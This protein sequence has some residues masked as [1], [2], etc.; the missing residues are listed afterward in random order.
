MK[1]T[2]LG[3]IT[4][5]SSHYLGCVIDGCPAGLE[6][7]KSDIQKELYADVPDHSLGT[8]RREQNGFEILSGL[9]ED[10]TLGTPIC[11]AINN[12]NKSSVDYE[13]IK[14]Y[15]RPGH[16]EYTYHKRYGIYS[17]YG[18]G[19][20]SGREAIARIAGGAVAKKLLL[21]N[22]ITFHSRVEEL[23][24]QDCSTPENMEHAKE[25]CLE[26]AKDGDSTGGIVSLVVK[27]IPAGVG[28]PVFDKL[29]SLVMFG[30][31]TIGGV[32]GVESG[33][34]FNAARMRG[35]EFNDP[36]GVEDGEVMPQ[37]N[38]AG[39]VLGGISTGLDLSFRIAIKPTP[40]IFKPQRTVNW[41]TMEEETLLLDG[42]F[43]KNFAPRVAPIAEAMAALVIADQMILA[44][45]ANPLRF[46]GQAQPSAGVCQRR[47][48]QRVARAELIP[49]MH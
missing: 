44:G 39:G 9:L 10:K 18:G 31:S 32:K 22:G 17:P 47:H 41:K 43:D 13:R 11:I 21:R 4:E 36:F 28:G 24:G 38:N 35:S 1:D 8:P 33:Q 19:R 45:Y 20:A 2:G 40:S 37:S 14:S 5:H 6:L 25:C 27:G 49:L 26:I 48:C 12:H 29:H 42:R 30:L 7:V 15:Y 23:A 34:G 16:A 3:Q 46:G